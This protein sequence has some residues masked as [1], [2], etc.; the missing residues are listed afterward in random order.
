MPLLLTG[1]M[2]SGTSLAA[3]TAI[4]AGISMGRTMVMPT[5]GLAP[6]YEDA[7]LTIRFSYAI[8]T[9]GS[10]A[11]A[12]LEDY[13]RWRAREQKTW[14]F[15]SPLALPFVPRIRA[16]WPGTVLVCIERDAAETYDAIRE[17]AERSGA[18]PDVVSLWHRTQKHLEKHYPA[19][20]SRADF[21][22]PFGTLVENPAGALR[23]VFDKLEV[24]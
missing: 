21:I 22:I 23:P 20:R 15:K 18:E 13:A 19:A 8:S 16:A 14:G 10:I 24:S 12:V 5:K 11:S 1:L 2:K 4:D 6:E 17:M 7:E 3:R 9:N